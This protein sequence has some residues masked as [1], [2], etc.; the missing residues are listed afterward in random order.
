MRFNR[1]LSFIYSQW[2]RVNRYRAALCWL[3]GLL[4]GFC[5]AKSAQYH[6]LSIAYAVAK[7]SVSFSYLAAAVMLPA[8]ISLLAFWLDQRWLADALAVCCGLFF[9]YSLTTIQLAYGNA[10][11][12]VRFLLMFSRCMT[13]PALMWYWTAGTRRKRWAVLLLAYFAAVFVFDYYF[14]APFLKAL[15]S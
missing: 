12:L 1:I 6:T 14:V 11:W 4:L 8:L 5:S 2:G 3:C 7:G 10:G 13:V 15:L 9:G